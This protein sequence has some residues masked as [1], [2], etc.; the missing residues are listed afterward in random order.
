MVER[1]HGMQEVGGSTPPE[2]TKLN[3]MIQIRKKH[4][5][6]P[7]CKGVL[8]KQNENRQTFGQILNPTYRCSACGCNF[9]LNIN[10]K[11]SEKL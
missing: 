11:K 8:I 4:D 3:H 6:C 7:R 1:L 5:R 9:E 10:R 2:S